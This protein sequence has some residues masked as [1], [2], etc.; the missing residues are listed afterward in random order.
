MRKKLNNNKGFSLVEILAVIV[1]LG[2]IST[3]G[4]VS[5]TRLVDSS[6]KHFYESQQN[7]L[8]L[9]AR[10]YVE[11]HKEIQPKNIGEKEK[12]SLKTLYDNNYLKDKIVDKNKIECYSEDKKDD[13]GKTIEKGSYVNVVKTGK[14]DLTYKGFLYCSSCGENGNCE[15]EMGVDE[16]QKPVVLITLPGNTGNT[17]FDETTTIN[18]EYF[19]KGNNA[20][21]SS[22][23]YRIY[24]DGHLVFNSGTKINSK[25]ATLK[26]QEPIYKYLPGVI[27]VVATITN[28]DG[29][30][31]SFSKT[32]D[33]TD[34]IPPSCGKI[35]YD[36]NNPLAA[37]DSSQTKTCGTTGYL[38]SNKTRHVWVVCN[39]FKGIGCSQPEFSK[40]L[41]TE[42]AKDSVIIKDNNNSKKTNGEDQSC[43]VMKCIDRTTPKITVKIY[44][45]GTDGKKTGGATKTFT[46]DSVPEVKITTKNETY[47]TWLNKKN[48]PNGVIVEVEITDIAKIATAKS[49]IKS[50]S[51][52]QNVKNQKENA[53]GETKSKVDL[54]DNIKTSTYTKTQRITD[55]GVRKQ[56]IVVTDYA[57]NITTYNLILKIDRTPPTVPT[58]NMKK[59][60]DNNTRPTSA[61]GL[62]NYP[63]DTWYSGKVYTYPSGSVDS[64]DVSGFKEYQYTTKGK[65]TNNT[66]K[67]AKERSIEAEGEST[68]VWRSCDN[69]GNC[70][71]YNTKK[72]IKLDRTNPKCT[73]RNSGGTSGNNGWYRGGTVTATGYCSDQTGLSGCKAA[74]THI[75]T[76]RSNSPNSSGTKKTITIYDKANNSTTCNSTIKY[77]SSSP[78]CSIAKSNTYTTGG[79]TLSTSCWDNGPS[80]VSSCGG[81][82]YGVRS[83]RTYNV[84]DYAGNGNSCSIAVYSKQQKRTCSSCARCAG[85]GCQTAN[86]CT[87]RCCGTYTTYDTWCDCY[88]TGDWGV[89]DYQGFYAA[90]GA[91]YKASCWYGAG[92][93]VYSCTASYHYH[94]NPKTCTSIRCCGCQ[95][96]NQSCPT[97]GCASWGGWYD[98]GCSENSSTQCRTL[99]Y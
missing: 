11:D 37:Y 13:S 3:V 80:G 88:G 40:E 83:S 19:A 1:I 75:Q 33:Y 87:N 30:T 84:Y 22:Y 34:A 45:S 61:T 10:A 56:N 70:S 29:E 66:D 26:V 38:W 9:A 35:K 69:A 28:T 60:K 18:L 54:K 85:A 51:W 20:L 62:A 92:I 67:A 74:S 79:V 16:D 73:V 93:Q 27:K 91:S 6:R 2:I 25:K 42:G 44:K 47:S 53:I 65:T 94:T 64:P 55:D 15:E 39:D 43:S 7:N 17:L 78:G 72:T 31:K 24:V 90:T 63:N 89:T 71:N 50:F 95:T 41:L 81:T 8:V 68:I 96:Y 99:Y 98:S 59:W 58:T 57:G 32:K 86:T 82:H 14:T 36:G 97:C 76:V 49:E 46:V 23:S 77:D 48:Y 52:Y 4:I 21:I 5:V 12:I